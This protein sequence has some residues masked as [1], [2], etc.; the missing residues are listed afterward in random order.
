MNAQ[1]VSLRLDAALLLE[2]VLLDRL[3]AIPKARQA[4][5]LRS[6]LV[7]G[8]VEEL[9]IGREI[10]VAGPGQGEGAEVPSASRVSRSAFASW[11][12]ERGARGRAA[13]LVQPVAAVGQ[14]P[15]ASAGEGGSKPL[16]HLR[17]VIG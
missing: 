10:G 17:K 11:L 13:R 1:R 14:A 2:G 3:A 15:A 8:L 5:W 6:L 16:A 7:R 9:R 4:H 12:A